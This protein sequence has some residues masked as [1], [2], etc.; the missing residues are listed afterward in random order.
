MILDGLKREAQHKKEIVE[1]KISL[2]NMTK[3][4]ETI[5]Q[6]QGKVNLTL[7]SQHEKLKTSFQKL[8]EEHEKL[9]CLHAALNEQL[10]K[11]SSRVDPVEVVPSQPAEDHRVRE[12]QSQVDML[13]SEQTAFEEQLKGQIMQQRENDSLKQHKEHVLALLKGNEDRKVQNQNLQSQVEELL[14]EKAELQRQH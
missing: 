14:S 10:A 3:L 13:R 1:L 6:E 12:L 8:T 7:Q 11:A 9:V 5:S 2:L 4:N